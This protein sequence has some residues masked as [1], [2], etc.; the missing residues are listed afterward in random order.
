MWVSLAGPFS[1]LLLAVVASIPLRLRLLPVNSVSSGMLPTPSS[2]LIEFIWI[3]LALMLFNLIPLAPL[4]GEKV[5]EFLFPPSWASVL[6]RIRPYSP[7]ILLALV[8]VG[9]LFGIDLLGSVMSP[10]LLSIMKL[11]LGVHG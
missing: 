11:L 5:A 7:L 2:F 3:N 6:D 10:A 8:F 4:D 1:N 9:P